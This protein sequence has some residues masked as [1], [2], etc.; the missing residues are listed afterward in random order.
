MRQKI[1]LS[2]AFLL[3]CFSAG[4]AL[5]TLYIRNTT[6]EFS[7]IIELHQIEYLRQ[8]LIVRTQSVQ[9]DLYTVR[10]PLAH[11]LDS[12]INNVTNLENAAK[13][14]LNC[15]HI[16]EVSQR[17]EIIQKLIQ[18]YQN[19]LSYYITASADTERI[20]RLKLDAASIGNQLLVNSEEMSFDASRRLG[21]LT[22][23]A[24]I[25]I[26]KVK[27]ILFITI[28]LTII[29]AIIIAIQITRSITKP[30]NELVN[31]TREIAK[32]DL[33]YTISYKDRSEFGE[34]ANNFNMMS[35]ALKDGYTKLQK[36]IKERQK[37]EDE[38]IKAQK[39]ESL[40]VLAG[41]IAHDFNNLLA[42][43]LGNIDLA[44]S[45]LKPEDE[46]YDIL[47]DAEN[48]SLRARDLTL[49][50]L[51]FSRGGTP[52]RETADISKIIKESSTFT[53]TGSNVSC[54]YVLPDNLC[55]VAVDKGQI[56]QVIH[57]LVLNARDAMPDGGTITIRAE[58][59][60]V[61]A[62]ENLPLAHGE[63]IK[64]SVEDH[65]IGIAEENFSKIFD[66]YFT[67]KAMGDQRGMGLG[68]AICYS[69]IKKHEGFIT[70]DSEIGKGTT[71]NIYLPHSEEK[72]ITKKSIK[73]ESLIPGEGRILFMDDE[74][75]VQNTAGKMLRRLGYMPEFAK[76]GV[77]AI[78]FYRKA[79]E[80]SL[81]FVAVI[82]DLTVP[83]K[84]GGK[85]AI[86]NLLEIDPDIK[87]IVS[88]GYSNNPI[89]T[90]F[91]EYGF[92]GVISKPYKITELSKILH[93]VIN[94]VED[95]GQTKE[96]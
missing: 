38:L 65:G 55:P 6:K 85:E 42:A 4:V 25:K 8:D 24:L 94:G 14:C 83:G 29:S 86:R 33:G 47:K 56:S 41:G 60:R 30:V 28:M 48:A 39:I 96:N 21:L 91:R 61:D 13:G 80:S 27:S 92:R 16:P 44:K 67:T 89:M 11:T 51:T 7:R 26:D 20:D 93:E 68:L 66:P 49:Q 75:I 35:L 37:I 59:V 69:I 2:M 45:D 46:L 79:K 88:S 64:I 19:A 22:K 84:M 50:L 57:N 95:S 3:I 36:E 40:G 17:L 82:M 32:G 87:A 5:S 90:D 53:L 81:P 77:E 73:E 12:I 10:T 62:A 54:E 58:N 31:A 9:S 1:I 34:L 72:Y 18:D 15:H 43:I 63:Y 74:E 52:I 70:V 71:F 78:E 23:S 76:D